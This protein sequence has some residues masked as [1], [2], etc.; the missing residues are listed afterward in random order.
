MCSFDS[1]LDCG[2][3]RFISETTPVIFARSLRREHTNEKSSIAV[4]SPRLTRVTLCVPFRI[5]NLLKPIG[6]RFL[7]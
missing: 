7:T 1:L 3:S 4:L 2:I 5:L 6:L